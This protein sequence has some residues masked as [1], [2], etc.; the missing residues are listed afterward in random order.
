MMAKLLT[1]I[2]REEVVKDKRGTAY[3]L[4][5]ATLVDVS[6]YSGE[7]LREIRAERGVGRPP[8]R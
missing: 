7:K 3:L 2:L 4:K 5:H 6:R 1:Q 8:K